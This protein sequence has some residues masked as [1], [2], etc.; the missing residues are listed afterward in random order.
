[1]GIGYRCQLDKLKS[2]KINEQVS[3][4]EKNISRNGISLI[5]TCW[6]RSNIIA[7]SAG[8]YCLKIIHSQKLHP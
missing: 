7:I 6:Q 2:K 3:Q 4:D 5:K 1:M 8:K